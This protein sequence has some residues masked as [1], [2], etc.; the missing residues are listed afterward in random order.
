MKD[1]G[2]GAASDRRA[3]RRA[4]MPIVSAFVDE[5]RQQ[6]PNAE[7]VYACENG[8][9]VGRKPEN[10]NVFDIPPDYCKPVPEKKK[11]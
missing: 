2:I 4:A 10:E 5:V 6:F 7:V 9:T 1:I 11:K 3:Q 8:I